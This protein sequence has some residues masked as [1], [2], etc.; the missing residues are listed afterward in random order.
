MAHCGRCGRL[1]WRSGCLV[2]RVT[3]ARHLWCLTY[4]L[5]PRSVVPD[6]APFDV[7]RRKDIRLRPSLCE[8]WRES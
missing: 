1:R 4:A 6:V 3:T 2:A 7:V 5:A 8:N